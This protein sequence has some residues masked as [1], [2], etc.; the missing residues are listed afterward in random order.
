MIHFVTGNFFDYNAQIRVNTVNCVGVMG[1]G[2]ALQF[3]NRFPKMFDEY[4]KEC[5]SGKLKIGEPH[6]WRDNEIFNNPLT[7]IN[8]PT[9]YDWRN[10]S[11][12][13]FIQKGL[14]WLRN[15]LKEKPNLSVTVPA[16][17]CGHGGLD[18]EIVKPMIVQYL[19]DLDANILVFEPESSSTVEVSE[20][21]ITS[22]ASAGVQKLAPSDSK[23]PRKLL[24][25]SAKEIY[26][27]GNL[28]IL[29]NPVLSII[30]DPNPSERE[31][32]AVT[33]C[34]P[35][36]P[37]TKCTYFLSYNSSFEKDLLKEVLHK[38]TKV[39]IIVPHGILNFKIRKDLQPL[40]DESRI[41]ILSTSKP[42]QS[43]SSYESINTLRLRF[44]LSD[45][46]FIGSQELNFL[47]KMEKDLKES[48]SSIFFINYW[49]EKMELYERLDA[50]QIGR[51]RDS[52][53][54]NFSLL[55]TKLNDYNN[56]R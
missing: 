14:S 39:A 18:W 53:S 11:E 5:N 52:L 27:K 50:K 6:V 49:N 48:Q 26:V 2:V 45:I 20:A 47:S 31:R 46:I 51:N 10:P 42:T 23:Y 8:F 3:K 37:E 24:G 21:E 38:Q 9:K 33:S 7:I 17:G 40:W 34:I 13:E 1:A 25:K 44:K 4:V 36:L 54:P 29:N 32:N 41:L 22:L 55:Y 43:W 12:Y 28:D 30:T 56:T 35:H 16:L 19:G 15:F